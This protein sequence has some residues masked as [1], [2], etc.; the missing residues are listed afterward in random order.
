MRSLV[1]RKKLEISNLDLEK[2]KLI[3]LPTRFSRRALYRNP[4]QIMN[5]L[6]VMKLILP[7]MTI[8]LNHFSPKLVITLQLLKLQG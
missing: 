2:L 8:W 1:S 4:I 3:S 5:P 7:T 6:K